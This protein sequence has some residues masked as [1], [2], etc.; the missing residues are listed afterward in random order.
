[1]GEIDHF[2]NLLTHTLLS[3]DT[4]FVLEYELESEE[5]DPFPP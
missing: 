5:N 1:M 2:A 4:D 3:N